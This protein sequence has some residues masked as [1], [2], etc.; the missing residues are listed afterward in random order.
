MR[1]V[2]WHVRVP[3]DDD[4][5][6]ICAVFRRALPRHRRIRPQV[7]ICMI[8][9]HVRSS[10]Q[11]WRFHSNWCKRVTPRCHYVTSRCADEMFRDG[12]SVRFEVDWVHMTSQQY[13]V[14]SVSTGFT[15]HIH[16]MHYVYSISCP[17]TDLQAYFFS[18]KHQCVLA[19]IMWKV[20]YECTSVY[21]ENTI[22]LFRW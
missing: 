7:K 14:E 22:C 1:H 17:E 21:V 6:A 18:K 9:V 16:K 15:Y 20:L 12:H 2:S 19:M 4:V 3:S 10:T 11:H 5:T 8:K 13:T